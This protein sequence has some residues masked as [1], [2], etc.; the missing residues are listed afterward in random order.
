MTEN[1]EDAI[2]Q[3]PPLHEW[4]CPVCGTQCCE[5]PELIPVCMNCHARK[6][7]F[8]YYCI[9]C[10]VGFR[11]PEHD[12]DKLTCPECKGG[13]LTSASMSNHRWRMERRKYQDERDKI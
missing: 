8:V 13:S 6:Y 7:P 1:K 11:S 9:E 2:N 3:Q 5:E 4:T 12:M 10:E